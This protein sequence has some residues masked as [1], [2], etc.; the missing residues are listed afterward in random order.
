M[1]YS[2]ASTLKAILCYIDPEKTPK[3]AFD[4]DSYA[5][6][7]RNKI[8]KAIGQRDGSQQ[9]M[10]SFNED[11]VELKRQFNGVCKNINSIFETIS[12]T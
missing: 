12:S 6:E 11:E 4:D 1:L 7:L 10:I 9:V 8:K 3:I 2:T 5:E